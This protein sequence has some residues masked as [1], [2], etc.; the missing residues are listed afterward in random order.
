MYLKIICQ[1]PMGIKRFNYKY[2]FQQSPFPPQGKVRKKRFIGSWRKKFTIISGK[3]PIL[4]PFRTLGVLWKHILL[5]LNPG[6]RKK[7]WVR[8]LHTEKKFVLKKF[9]CQ[10]LKI[11]FIGFVIVPV[12]CILHILTQVPLWVLRE[13]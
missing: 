10:S 5:P 2:F 7:R 12:M 3:T 6:E 1:T 11:P 13:M 4:S 9:F 8:T